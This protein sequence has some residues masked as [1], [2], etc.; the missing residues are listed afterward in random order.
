MAHS[1]R[2]P[3]EFVTLQL[4]PLETV[5]GLGSR[6]APLSF[7]AAI[8][9]LATL[10]L[11]TIAGYINA[12]TSGFL[13]MLVVI[14]A[15]LLIGRLSRQGHALY[16]YRDG[17]VYVRRG[18]VAAVRFD[19]IRVLERVTLLSTSYRVTTGERVVRAVVGNSEWLCERL[20]YEVR[21][22]GGRVI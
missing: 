16:L 13:C 6:A 22:R 1:L 19:D 12:L 18:A 7:T 10:A 11:G 8:G 5:Y 9:L 14:G 15:I 3:P 21:R 17:L 2:E 4:G 20:E